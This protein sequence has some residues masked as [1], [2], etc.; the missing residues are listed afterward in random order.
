MIRDAVVMG[1]V[2]FAGLLAYFF[3]KVAITLNE[4]ARKRSARW[5]RMFH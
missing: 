2:M 1:I 3:I 5:T 4:D